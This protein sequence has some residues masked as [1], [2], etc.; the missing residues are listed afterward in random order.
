MNCFFH[1]DR[2]RSLSCPGSDLKGVHLL[3]CYDDAKEIHASSVG[4]RA[5]VIGAS[6]IGNYSE[7][8]S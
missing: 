6:F 8:E 1:I 3:Q 7:L 5:V 2:A 4:Q